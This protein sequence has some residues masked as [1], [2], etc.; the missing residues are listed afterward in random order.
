MDTIKHVSKEENC[1]GSF[2][3]AIFLFSY[4]GESRELGERS[5]NTVNKYGKRECGT[6]YN[7]MDIIHKVIIKLGEHAYIPVGSNDR[8]DF[9][10]GI[11]HSV[12]WPKNKE[13]LLK[14]FKMQT[15][16]KRIIVASSALS[17]GVNFPDIRYVINWGPARTLLDQLQ[18]AGRAG[19]DE[20]LSHA[21]TIYHG[22]QLS[23]CEDEV[24]QFVR[25]TGC[26]LVAVYKPFDPVIVPII[27]GHNCCL[28]CTL[29]CGCDD[30]RDGTSKKY[31]FEDKLD[32]RCECNPH[33]SRPVSDEDKDVLLAALTEL[34]LGQGN[35]SSAFGTH[36]FS[37]ELIDDIVS[38]CHKLFTIQDIAENNLPVYSIGHSLKILEVIQEIFEDIPNL[39]CALAFFSELAHCDYECE[40][41]EE[42]DNEDSYFIDYL[43]LSDD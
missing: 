40:N 38:N 26:Y 36:C 27:P 28:H 1:F 18:E 13:K 23:H 25:T 29:D 6:P 19:R 30:C 42:K 5:D 34:S 39:D 24:K 43:H 37:P 14:D 9:I 3:H 33:L 35:H 16:K 21:I 22:H 4:Y 7:T 17:M 32:V 11:F 8:R 12:S 10:L 31:P 15:S 41:T 20:E 2:K